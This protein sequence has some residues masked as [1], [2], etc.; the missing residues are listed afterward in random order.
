MAHNIEIDPTTKI[1]DIAFYST[2]ACTNCGGTGEVPVNNTFKD[3]AN[4]DKVEKDKDTC[5]VCK[6]ARRVPK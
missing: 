4:I 5:P 1:P 6:G 2:K 3:P